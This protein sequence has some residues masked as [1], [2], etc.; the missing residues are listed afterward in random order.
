MEQKL[1]DIICDNIIRL[2][3]N[4]KITVKELS[5][6]LGM[7]INAISDWRHSSPSIERLLRVADYFGV[8]VDYLCG[9][10][11]QATATA[12]GIIAVLKTLGVDITRLDSL[13]AD[14]AKVIA[15]LLIK[16]K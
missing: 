3:K 8:S 13:T 16:N 5:V 9:R 11:E 4:Q 15:A 7:G 12:S 14:D 2:C 6:Q 10:S 1:N